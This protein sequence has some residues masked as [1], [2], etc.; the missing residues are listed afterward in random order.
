MVAW[1]GHTWSSYSECGE[2]KAAIAHVKG[3]KQKENL[4]RNGMIEK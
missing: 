3:Q 1:R 4:K 2:H